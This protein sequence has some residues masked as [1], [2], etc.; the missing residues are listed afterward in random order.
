MFPLLRSATALSRFWLPTAIHHLGGDDFDKRITNWMI[1]EFKK[2][3]GVDLSGDKMALQ[4]LK[5]AAEKAKKE[6]STATTTNINLPFITATAEGP[7]HL[8]MNL[9]RAKFDELTA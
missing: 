1:D 5:E 4:R 9:T 2:A 7:K 6:L 8:D 3:E